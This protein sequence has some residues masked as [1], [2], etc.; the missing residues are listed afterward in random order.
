MI[1]LTHVLTV[2]RSITFTS[3]AEIKAAGSRAS[4]ILLIAYRGPNIRNELRPEPS[5][6]IGS[7]PPAFGLKK[8]CILHTRSVRMVLTI[9]STNRLGSVTDMQWAEFCR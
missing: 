4:L 2:K 7:Q 5:V 6:Y 8:L 9:N 3:A 1:L